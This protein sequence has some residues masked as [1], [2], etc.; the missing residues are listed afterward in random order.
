MGQDVNRKESTEMLLEYRR[1]KI[2]HLSEHL[3]SSWSL[4][5]YGGLSAVIEPKI[6]CLNKREAF[7]CFVSFFFSMSQAWALPS[8]MWGCPLWTQDGHPCCRQVKSNEIKKERKKEKQPAPS[9]KMRS[10]SCTHTDTHIYH[11]CPHPTGQT[12]VM[13]PHLAWKGGLDM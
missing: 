7:L 12:W 13:W 6:Q 10:W 5:Y 4:G 9:L 8:T 1:T 2:V 3:E 11:F